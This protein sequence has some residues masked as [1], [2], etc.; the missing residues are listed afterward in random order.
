M[1]GVRREKEIQVFHVG[2]QA[3]PSRCVK[4]HSQECE[5]YYTSLW[6]LREVPNNMAWFVLVNG[7]LL[8]L[9]RAS[10]IA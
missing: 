3:R 4:Q 8:T 9:I 6:L 2:V 1:R 10:A 7:Q 5:L